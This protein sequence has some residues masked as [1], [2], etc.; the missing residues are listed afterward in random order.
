V[1]VSQNGTYA[2]TVSDGY[3]A[4]VDSVEIQFVAQQFGN[5]PPLELPPDTAL[6]PQH[7]PYML[8]P[9]SAFSQ[10]FFLDEKPVASMPVELTEEGTYHLAVEVDGCLYADTFS[11]EIKDC[12]TAVY[13]PNVFSPNGDGI[14]D[15]F[16]PQGKNFE[17]LKLSV[18]DRWGGKGL[19]GRRQRWRGMAGAK[20]A[21]GRVRVRAG[22]RGRFFQKKRSGERG[23]DGGEVTAS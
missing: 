22:V 7:L 9:E 21:C 17:P 13:L 10:V 8:T 5:N 18:Y 1:E 19:R 3:C 23:G 6:Y 14:N 2:A 11:L 16:F 20:R 4:A 15:E 12:E